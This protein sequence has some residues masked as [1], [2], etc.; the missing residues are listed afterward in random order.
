MVGNLKLIT[1]EVEETWQQDEKK[2]AAESDTDD[3]GDNADEEQD[4]H[5]EASKSDAEEGGDDAVAEKDVQDK[6][7]D[8]DA[9]Y[10]DVPEQAADSDADEEEEAADDEQNVEDA[11]EVEG[12]IGS[13]ASQERD[14]E[15]V[16]DSLQDSVQDSPATARSRTPA[17]SD[18][19]IVAAPTTWHGDLP[20]W[21]RGSG[22]VPDNLHLHARIVAEE[23]AGVGKAAA[24]PHSRDR[25]SISICGPVA[26][27][28][29]QMVARVK[30]GRFYPSHPI[31]DKTYATYP[32]A[33]GVSDIM[34]VEGMLEVGARRSKIYD[35]LLEHDQ[36]VIKADVDNMVH[37]FASSVSS[38]DDKDATAA[39]VGALAAEDP[40]NW[41]SIAETESVGDWSDFVVYRIHAANVQSLRGG[42][43]G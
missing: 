1:S 22:S 19:V 8:S 41:M 34:V 16:Q 36:N 3:D 29:Q 2:E 33:R 21:Q 32:C 42:P 9:E 10:Q 4:A 14:D 20:A 38:L 13:S 24:S 12:A 18:Q 6:D 40:M 39:E 31:T 11:K 43:V 5:D 30:L 26:A 28:P 17:D 37:D 15:S 27:S 23:S 7:Q 35:Y 25:L